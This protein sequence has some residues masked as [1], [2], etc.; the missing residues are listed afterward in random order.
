MRILAADIGGTNSRFAVFRAT[1]GHLEKETGLSLPSAGFPGFAALLARAWSGLGAG[2]GDID[3]AALAVAGPV[4][5]RSCRP[6]NIAWDID[7]DRDWPGGP[8][9]ALLNDFLA[10]AYACRTSAVARARVV[11]AGSADPLG[12]TAVVGAG[13]GLG[14]CALLPLG[15]GFA[16]VPSEGGHAAFA[17]VGPEEAAY[18]EF[19]RRET[20]RPYAHGDLVVTGP[21]LSLLHRFLT[22]RDLSPAEAAAELGP[23]SPTLAWFSRFY[24]RACRNYALI[25]LATGGLY[26]SGGLAAKNPGLVDNDHFRSEF[27]NSPAHAGLLRNLPV[28][29][30]DNEDSGLFGA[31]LFGQRS[32]E[33]P[34]LEA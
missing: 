29:L 31:A 16:A 20:G 14:H 9:C 34:A 10:Q 33:R 15:S 24:A 21:G 6:P 18:E 13:T 12:V 30:N 2:P 23:D 3:A 19:L 25:V 8:P 5:G 4:R 7:L 27:T 17:F 11:Q 28:L 32:L 22:G 1:A 26:I